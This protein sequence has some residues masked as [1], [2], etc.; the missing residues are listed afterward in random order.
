MLILLTVT[1]FA[2]IVVVKWTPNSPVHKTD[3]LI[4]KTHVII[5]KI[6]DFSH[7]KFM[8]SSFQ[9]YCTLDLQFAHQHIVTAPQICAK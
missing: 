8:F 9:I 5:I 3:H 1:L 6:A 2:T 7:R 4:C